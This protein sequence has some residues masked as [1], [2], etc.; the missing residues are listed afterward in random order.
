[1]SCVSEPFPKTLTK[2]GGGREGVA[3]DVWLT[4]TQPTGATTHDPAVDLVTL[5]PTPAAASVFFNQNEA[6][7]IPFVRTILVGSSLTES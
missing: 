5:S 1:M 4:N 7:L 2:L 3:C 6:N